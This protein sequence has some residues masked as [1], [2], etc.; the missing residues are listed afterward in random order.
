MKTGHILKITTLLAVVS[1]VSACSSNPKTNPL[2]NTGQ[3]AQ[4]VDTARGPSLTLDDVLFDFEQSSLRPEAQG[5]IAQAVSYLKANPQRRAIVEGHTDTSGDAQF[6]HALSIKRS[7][8]IKQAMMS[9]GISEQKIEVSGLGE[10]Q[11]V[12]DNSTLSGRQANRRVEIIFALD[13]Q[14]I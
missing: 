3:T 11:P 4:I 10:T 9:Q 2:G 12:A 5:T 13:G 6:N 8:S 7:E 1:V 14:D